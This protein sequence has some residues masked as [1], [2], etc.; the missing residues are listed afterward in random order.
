[1]KKFDATNLPADGT[2][3]KV[4]T[5]ERNRVEQ[6]EGRVMFATTE[7]IRL[8]QGGGWWDIKFSDVTSIVEGDDPRNHK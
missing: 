4:T 3:V 1:V 6:Y 8:K 5:N 2:W 7:R